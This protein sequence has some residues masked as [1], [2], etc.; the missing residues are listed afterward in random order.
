[1]TQGI[2]E[3][4]ELLKG[5][6]ALVQVIA[7]DLIDGLSLDDLMKIFAKYQADAAKKAAIEAALKDIQAVPAEIKDLSLVE[8]V[9]LVVVLAQELPA[10]LDAFKK[11]EAV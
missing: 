4:K 6:S 2:K 11:P 10:I 3:S 8:G 7:P 9:D 1:M 5:V